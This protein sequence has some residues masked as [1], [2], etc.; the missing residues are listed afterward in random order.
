MFCQ[1]VIVEYYYIFCGD[2]PF[3]NPVIVYSDLEYLSLFFWNR[4]FPNFR[5]ASGILIF[6]E[7]HFPV[8]I[9]AKVKKLFRCH[10][11]EIRKQLFEIPIE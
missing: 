4:A 8:I 1:M 3:Q 9:S 6:E 5:I 10:F 2:V 11:H 7:A